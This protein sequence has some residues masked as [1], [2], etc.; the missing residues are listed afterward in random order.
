MFQINNNPY[1]LPNVTL[2][3][4]WNDTKGDTVVATRAMTE[5]ICDGVATFF[6]P[7]G[8][9]NVEG[10]V[11]QSRNIPMISYVSIQT[12][13]VVQDPGLFGEASSHPHFQKCSD[14]LASPIPTFARTEPPDTQVT[15]SIISMLNYYGW[16]KFSVIYDITW[17]NVAKSLKMQAELFNMTLNHKR[18]VHDHHKCCEQDLDC[19]RTGYWY[20]TV[21]DTMK[22][23]RI[24]VFLGPIYT[25]HQMVEAM[26]SLKVF[27]SG[28][29]MVIYV[30]MLTYL[31]HESYKYIF[32]ADEL[33]KLSCNDVEKYRQRARSL[34]VLVSTPPASSYENFTVK[35][36]E[37]NKR[38]PFNF[39]TPPI[40][41]NYVKFVSI[42]AAYLYDSVMLYAMALDQLL[43][44]EQKIQKLTEEVIR[45]VASNGTRIVE[46]I[47]QNRT[48]QSEWKESEC[49]KTSRLKAV[50]L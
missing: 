37:Y 25:Y 31:P 13:C 46:T 23:T 32:S 11:S 48:Y 28:D 24:Y 15:K 49:E 2:A 33:A 36:R 18:V 34:L 7:E 35:V 42:Y 43:R 4:R 1:I 12:V 39:S 47:I 30:D 40:F 19:C 14:H 17:E 22:H 50:L 3:M 8:S 41:F 45:N 44:N 9:C 27:E 26:D 21:R 16:K 10:I 5:M 29:Y 38:E 20:Q 6:G